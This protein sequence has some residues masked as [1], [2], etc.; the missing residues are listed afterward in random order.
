M[1]YNEF[2]AGREAGG[3]GG[4]GGSAPRQRT[5]MIFRRPKRP[6]EKIQNFQNYYC[7][8]NNNSRLLGRPIFNIT[9]NITNQFK[10]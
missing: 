8:N 5:L 7:Y 6:A 9:I 4:S 3:P 1:S 10:P 2:V